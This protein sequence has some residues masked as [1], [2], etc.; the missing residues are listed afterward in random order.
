[1]K[2]VFDYPLINIIG[3]LLQ[4]FLS[5][6]LIYNLMVFFVI[7]IS[8]VGTYLLVKYL[9]KNTYASFIAGLVFGFT[10]WTINRIPVGHLELLNVQFIPFFVLY[11]IK[12]FREKNIKNPIFASIFLLLSS[13]GFFYNAV[14]LM[15]FI[16][17]FLLYMIIVDRK[18]VLNKYF[19][20]R[21]CL[22]ILLFVIMLLPF[23][24]PMIKTGPEGG[25]A[26]FISSVKT[27][28][29]IGSYFVPSEYHTIFGKYVK[30]FRAGV[31]LGGP[32]PKANYIGFSIL[33][34][35]IYAIAKVK[36]KETG[37][38]IISGAI[39][40][41]LALG[42]ILQFFGVVAIPTSGLGLDVLV[43]NIFP[44]TP[45]RGLDILSS[46]LVIPLPYTILHFIPF[47]N[48]ARDPSRFFVIALL[49][50]SVL[51]GFACKNLFENFKDKKLF[52]KINAKKLLMVIIPLIIFF[53]FMIIPLPYSSPDPP[54][55]YK[56][57]ISDTE[58]YAIFEIPFHRVI[59]YM[60]FQTFHNK[61]L[62][63]G[64]IGRIPESS[65][66]FIK[67]VPFLDLMSKPIQI[68]RTEME[69]QKE[70][71]KETI[72]TLN[73]NNIKYVIFHKT[74]IHNWFMNETE[75]KNTEILLDYIFEEPYYEDEEI[76]IYQ[77]NK[78]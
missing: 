68:N 69:K 18:G 76:T 65:K 63:N 36:R 67:S 12:T 52:N 77:V 39:F 33:F 23:I 29:D 6:T 41:L 1:M 2:K 38:W 72:S 32:T 78:G 9:T 15:I 26:P 46:N 49:C 45:K 17:I 35:V 10:S 44:E 31:F 57:I 7:I 16:I 59:E 53:E 3:L 62:V 47:V 5:L 27:S 74:Y 4:P 56:Q 40:I 28:S 64:F 55:A 50:F 71:S 58:E 75:A 20:K 11:L 60:Y 14:F 30:D 37:L 66:E 51:V 61:K 19:I 70:L 73:E 48:V 43:Q 21:F 13:I 25:T 8:A 22:M 54:E 42:P 34:L 24:Y